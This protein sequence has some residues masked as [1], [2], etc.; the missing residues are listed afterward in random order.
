M[1][2]ATSKLNYEK[3]NQ[4]LLSPQTFSELYCSNRY[5]DKGERSALRLSFSISGGYAKN[6]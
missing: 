4:L 3:E 2:I 5:P 1:E 6:N